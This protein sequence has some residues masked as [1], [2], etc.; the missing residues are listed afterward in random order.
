[1]DQENKVDIVATDEVIAESE[2]AAAEETTEQQ[3]IIAEE[4]VS[5]EAPKTEAV[6]AKGR[7][8]RKK[9]PKLPSTPWKKS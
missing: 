5:E 6:E 9:C 2:A 3:A 4:A 8:A 7:S 1:M